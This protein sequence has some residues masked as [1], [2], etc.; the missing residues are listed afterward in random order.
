MFA[1]LLGSGEAL[2]P[3]EV[4]PRGDGTFLIADGVHR[5]AAALAT[6]QPQVGAIV[7]SVEAGESCEACAFRRALET[8]TQSALPLSNAERRDAV[9]K[10][11]AGAAYY[12]LGFKPSST[13]PLILVIGGGNYS[14]STTN[15][16]TLQFHVL[17][18]TFTSGPTMTTARGEMGVVSVGNKTYTVG[19]ATPCCGSSSKAFEVLTS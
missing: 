4:V 7:L 19:G 16:T 13:D 1:A 11:V 9:L 8:A 10:L 6:N 2:P 17:K 18:S 14:T 12:E 15:S 3:I 5:S